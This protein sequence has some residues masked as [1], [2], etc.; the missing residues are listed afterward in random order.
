MG[1]VSNWPG[2]N[3]STFAGE[4][5]ARMDFGRQERICPLATSGVLLPRAIMKA[6]VGI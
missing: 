5:Q 4:T 6:S 1:D 3:G 2:A